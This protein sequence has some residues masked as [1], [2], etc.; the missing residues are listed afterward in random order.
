MT[1]PPI[2]LKG[3]AHRAVIEA[4]FHPDFPPEVGREIQALRQA[5]STATGDVQDLRSLLW[6]SIDNDQSRDLDQIEYVERL[7]D[8]TMRLLVGVA[9]VD[10]LVPKASATDR[11]A[12]LEATSVYTGV[13]TFPML[14]PELS[15]DLTSLL[16]AQERLSLV[17]EMQVQDT[18]EVSDK[19]LYRAQVR[20]Q[21]KLTYSATG[22]WLE[23]RGPLPPAVANVPGMEAQLRLQRET[24]ERLRGL[25]KQHGALTFAAAEATPVVE[26]DQITDLRLNHHNAAEDIIESFMVAANVAMAQLLRE[27]GALSIRR[28]VREPRRW[29][30][31]Q[32]I[33]ARL[34]A[35]L[36]AAPDSRALSEFLAAQQTADPV[37]FPDLSLCVVKLLGPGE[38][39]VEAPGAEQQGHFGLAVHDYTHS[40][41]PNRRYADLVT[42]RLLKGIVAHS[43]APYSQ[44]ELSEIAAHCTEREDAARKV[45][46]L[47]RKVVAASVLSARLDETF[48]GVVTGASP[49]GTYVRLVKFPAE[50]RV[51]RG[52]QG[53][54]V[55]DRVRVRLVSVDVNQGFIDFE[56][57]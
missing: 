57:I 55:G 8:G 24:S 15:T 16:D 36:P 32:E 7:P 51:V 26:N 5:Q 47:M 27:S 46:R 39:I 28:V 18:G 1:H 23:G 2:D 44:T 41:A 3:R 9:E 19:T 4:G 53:I 37:H 33:A 14:P 22:A 25:R 34:G 56:R 13:A 50:G 21:A 49:K 40:T 52:A 17:V 35:Q 43:P 31:I 38:Y 29:E 12:G 20:N 48:E 54:D 30:R 10:A 11:Q 6:S 45:E 42:Q